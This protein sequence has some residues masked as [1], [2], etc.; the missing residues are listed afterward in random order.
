MDPFS[1]QPLLSSQR[2]QAVTCSPPSGDASTRMVCH[3]HQL[4]PLHVRFHC[5]SHSL[6]SCNHSSN[7]GTNSSQICVPSNCSCRVWNSPGRVFTFQYKSC[8]E[9]LLDFWAIS[10]AYQVYALWCWRIYAPRHFSW[11]WFHYFW[12]LLHLHSLESTISWTVVHEGWDHQ[13]SSDF[14]TICWTNL[15]PNIW[16]HCICHDLILHICSQLLQHVEGARQRICSNYWEYLQH[17]CL[18]QIRWTLGVP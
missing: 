12:W 8:H 13:F 18:W 17:C 5:L 4:N 2:M 6:S 9:I 7:C 14:G 10:W 1:E 16:H 11:H 15:D 3:F